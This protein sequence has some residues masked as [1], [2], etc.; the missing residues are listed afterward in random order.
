MKCSKRDV[1]GVKRSFK[2]CNG[3]FLSFNKIEKF[4][5]SIESAFT[6]FP[7]LSTPRLLLRQIRSTDAN[8][9]FEVFS[10][11]DV[12]QFDSNPLYTSIEDA[13]A[14]IQKLQMRYE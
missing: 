13:E 11:Q 12:M 2:E 1:C 14:F 4:F 3:I 10:D 9:I 5:M 8:A 6:Q 7:T